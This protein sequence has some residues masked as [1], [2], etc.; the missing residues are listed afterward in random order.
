VLRA[1]GA[2]PRTVWLIIVAEGLAIG[3]LAWLAA[4]LVAWP[5]SKLLG[6]LLVKLMFRSDLD[7]VFEPAGLF[8]WLAISLT[9][10]TVSSLVPAWQASRRPVQ[11]ALSYE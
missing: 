1:I 9:L 4:A 3:L 6:D 11:E 2:T 8:A 5:V 10:A 7:F